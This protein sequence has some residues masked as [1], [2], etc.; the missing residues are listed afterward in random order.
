MKNIYELDYEILLK[1]HKEDYHTSSK[2]KDRYDGLIRMFLRYL[3]FNGKCSFGLSLALNKLFVHQIIRLSDAEIYEYSADNQIY[4]VVTWDKIL[5]F[6]ERMAHES[7]SDTVLK[8]SKH[9]LTL[10]YIFLDMHKVQ[11]L[12]KKLLWYWFDKS[13]PV[14][15]TGWKQCR[16]SICQFVDYLINNTITTTVTGNP[17]AIKKIDTLPFSLSKPL[18]DYLSLLKRE[19]MQPSTIN[20]YRSSNLRFCQ[21]IWSV[22]IEKFSDITAETIKE[23]NLQDK[24]IT[25]EGKAAYNCRIRNFLIYLYEEKILNESYLYNALPVAAASSHTLVEILSKEDVVSIWSVNPDKLSSCELRDYAM[26]CIGLTMGFRASDIVSLRF[27]NIN[28]KDKSISIVQRKTGKA[29]TMPMPIKTGNILYKYIRFA[30]PKSNESCV[31]IHSKAPYSNLQPS[32]C[33]KA[34]KRFLDSSSKSRKFHSV[35]KTFATQLLE[36]NSKVELISDS[37]GH[38]TDSTVHEYLS[39]NEKGMRM[40]ALSL[41]DSSISYTGGAFDA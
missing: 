17:T 14:L 8:T 19:G 13:R 5:T 1:F 18:E 26:V 9:I 22:G 30:R 23:F 10:F 38:S 25:P 40:C 3:A 27:E 41:A 39:L 36:S 7:Y 2:T 31:F 28:W 29:L 12:T 16:R 37:L 24:H 33:G 35:R 32:A 20:M 34:L 15:G 6:L 4:P 11:R 21:Y